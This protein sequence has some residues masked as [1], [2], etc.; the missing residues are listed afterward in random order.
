MKKQRIIRFRQG[1]T[2]IEAMMAMVI[3]AIAA[4]GILM[5]FVAAASVQN[6]AQR[7]VIASR[8]AADLLEEIAATDYAQIISTYHG[9]NEVAGSLQD[10]TGATMTGPAYHGLSRSAI[11]QAA[12]VAGVNLIW[13]TVEVHC[14]GAP[15]AK[16]STLVGDKYKN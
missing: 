3:L 13:V 1:F 10:R 12:T 2:L 15:I 8:L 14:N 11:C 6:E 4:S 7:Q 5:S 9:Y 16:L